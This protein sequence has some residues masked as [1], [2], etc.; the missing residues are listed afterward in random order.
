MTR[1]HP[2]GKQMRQCADC[3]AEIPAYGNR[4]RCVDC[5]DRAYRNRN[6][7]KARPV[8]EQPKV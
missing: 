8:S 2:N 4:K 7:R 6:S 5:Q 3:P 1:P